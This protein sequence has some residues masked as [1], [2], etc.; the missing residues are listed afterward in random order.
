MFERRSLKWPIFLAVLMIVLLV[1]LT[2]GWILLNIAGVWYSETSGAFYWVLLSIGSAMF[3]AV[4]VGVVLYLVLAIQQINLN[5]RQSNFIDSVTHELKS[6]IASLK[7]YLQTLSRR[8]IAEEQR[9]SFYHSMLTDVERLDK[10]I[11]QLL[12]TARLS[13][14]EKSPEEEQ[15]IRLDELIREVAAEVRDRYEIQEEQ[16]QL[17][18]TPMTVVARAGDIHIIFRNLLDNAAKYASTPAL[19]HVCLAPSAKA[20]WLRVTVS[21]NGTGVPREMRR[22]VFGRFVRVGDELE[23]TKPGTGLGLFLVRSVVKKMRGKIALLD[24]PRDSGAKFEVQL[25]KASLVDS[26]VDN[27]NESE[28]PALSQEEPQEQAN[29]NSESC[30]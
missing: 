5:R 6:P 1:S 29:N 18:L 8:N 26:L 10:L 30:R 17:E 27:K 2:V 9:N 22:Q 4:V 20:N 23:R 19:I 13:H 28:R 11:N 7:L 14:H 24:T 3:V 15:T 25:P 12:E 16:V 21:D